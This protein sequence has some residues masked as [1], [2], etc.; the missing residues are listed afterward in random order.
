[1]SQTFANLLP[2]PTDT[3]RILEAKILLAIKAGGG[4]G[5]GGSGQLLQYTG[6]SPTA[7]GLVPANIN[8]PAEAYKDDGTLPTYTWNTTSH[9]W[10][11]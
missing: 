3:Q 6:A 11:P 4:G 1:M 7:D 10:N 5:G 9:T 2:Q 8:L